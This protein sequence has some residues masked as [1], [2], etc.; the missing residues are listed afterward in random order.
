MKTK[1]FFSL[2]FVIVFFL[3]LPEPNKNV[4]DDSD[5]KNLKDKNEK[6]SFNNSF[7]IRNVRL[8]DG[9]KRYE[10]MDVFIKGNKLYR[11]E[12]NLTKKIEKQSLLP[13]MDAQGMTLLPGLIDS[14]T[15]V[16]GEALEE[17]L[18]FGVT[19]ELDMFSVSAAEQLGFKNRDKVSHQ[20]AADLFSSTILATA[21]GGHGTQFGFE[22]PVLDS[23]E[24][25]EQFVQARVAAGADYIKAVYN[26]VLAKHQQFPSISKPILKALILTAHKQGRMLV[27]HVDNLISAKEAIRLGAD[28]IIHSFMD[29]LVDAE[30][31][32][33][34]KANN[35]FIITTLSVEASIAG[36]SDG[37]R[38]LQQEKLVKYLSSQ[39]KQQLKLKFPDFGL[40][41]SG[42]QKAFDSIKILSRAGITI[43]AGSDAPNPGTSHG[44]SLHGELELLVRA[45]LSNEQVLHSATA[46]ARGYFPIGLRGTLKLNALAS[47]ILIDGNPFEDISQTQN[48]SRI[49]KNGVQL[50]RKSYTEKT[51]LN[52]QISTGLITDFNHSLSDT[53]IGSE[54]VATTDRYA[55]GKS[56]V[57]L[58]LLLR[59]NKQGKF[60]HI[61]GEIKKGFM[62]PWSGIGYSPGKNWQQGVDL[63]KI[64]A[65]TFDAKAGKNT[66]EFSVLLFQ[67]GS[68][69]PFTRIVKL[70]KQWQNY[71]VKLADYRNADLSNISN[72]S[73]VVTKQQGKFEFMIDNVKFE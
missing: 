40:A 8:Y 10:N 52:K 60:L 50:K 21:P 72:I 66:E 35:A 20:L 22:I 26:S 29:K 30:F 55:G 59:K 67:Q 58:T 32:E 45:G 62:Y 28:G 14:H 4:L 47:M 71:K 16:Y 23:P 42:L 65:M 68:F 44:V 48:I 46:A 54:I 9:Y 38:L 69:T 43:L 70:S 63:S 73:I 1:L 3:F 33:M 5:Q 27:V 37:D 39:Q 18:N 57:E 12:N 6:I 41:E 51:T 11:I 7:I 49:W 15:H 19:T 31:V 25:A 2:C 64:T 53:Q 13:E 34:M 56:E 36:L 24:Q 17:A 61:K